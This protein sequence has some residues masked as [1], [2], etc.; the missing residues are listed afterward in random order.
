MACTPLVSFKFIRVHVL[1]GCSCIG[2]L[3]HDQEAISNWEVSVVLVLIDR[4]N[5]THL[6]EY[7]TH[8][9]TDGAMDLARCLVDCNNSVWV[10]QFFFLLLFVGQLLKSQRMS[11]RRIS[12]YHS[13]SYC[14]NRSSSRR[15]LFLRIFDTRL[16]RAS[17]IDAFSSLNRSIS[18]AINS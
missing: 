3:R 10:W 12:G 7:K 14:P 4:N 2:K 5:H 9:D 1:Q 13:H 17:S 11:S 15:L 8:R 16:P 18:S 6:G